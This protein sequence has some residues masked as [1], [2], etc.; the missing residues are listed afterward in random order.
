[1]DKLSTYRTT[2]ECRP[3]GGSVTYVSTRVV[4]WD[5][6]KVVLNSGGET[7]YF[8]NIMFARA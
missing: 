6:E 2:F 8:D 4:S 3:D 5:K 7:P 1:M